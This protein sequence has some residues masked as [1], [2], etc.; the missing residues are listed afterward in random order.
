MV[1]Q[2]DEERIKKADEPDAPE[3][4][5]DTAKVRIKRVAGADPITAFSYTP[6]RTPEMDSQPHSNAMR[7]FHPDPNQDVF[8]V[9]ADIAAAAVETGGFE[10]DESSRVKLKT[11][12]APAPTG[13]DHLVMDS[14]SA[15]I[16]SRV[17]PA[18]IIEGQYAGTADPAKGGE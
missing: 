4:Q 7:D 2:L 6:F 17:G 8:E 13:S 12:E 16:L 10:V 11:T 15:E 3:A 18:E 1:D 5:R 14:A 9:S